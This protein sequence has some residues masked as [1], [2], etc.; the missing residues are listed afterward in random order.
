[1]N[2]SCIWIPSVQITPSLSKQRSALTHPYR[3]TDTVLKWSE[4]PNRRQ[5]KADKSVQIFPL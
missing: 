5:T 1:M 4:M 3:M 2:S